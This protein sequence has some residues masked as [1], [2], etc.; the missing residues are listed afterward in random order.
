MCTPQPP[1]FAPSSL[2][3]V[4]KVRLVLRLV[5]L[6][7]VLK[8]RVLRVRLPV[9]FEIV[10]TQGALAI[11]RGDL[12]QIRRLAA[13][14]CHVTPTSLHAFR[15]P[16]VD[17]KTLSEGLALG[18]VDGDA[19][20]WAETPLQFAVRHLQGR[21]V[22]LRLPRLSVDLLEFPLQMHLLLTELHH[23]PDLRV[24]KDDLLLFLLRFPAHQCH[25]DEKCH[26]LRL[27][28]LGV[29]WDDA[30]LLCLLRE[31]A[32]A[33]GVDTHAGDVRVCDV[34]LGD[35]RDWKSRRV[36]VVGRHVQVEQRAI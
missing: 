11:T 30:R 16:V 21:H 17:R 23:K 8:V 29:G 4:L 27:V 12:D 26:V 22:L 10:P 1:H 15:V 13:R 31:L 6:S 19:V 35:L 5:R 34:Q 18:H 2:A 33:L 20:P 9:V 32:H 7:V 25:A 3:V 36:H 28:I 24:S 14:E